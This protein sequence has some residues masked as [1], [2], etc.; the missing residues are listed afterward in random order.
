MSKE[1]TPIIVANTHWDLPE[2]IIKYVQEERM[3]NGLIDMATPLSSEE[4]VGFAEVVAYIMPE[5][6]QRPVASDVAKI[7]LYCTT[8]LMKRHKIEVPED[9]AIN[10]L[11]DYEMQKLNDLKRRIYKQRGGKEK[12]PLINAFKEVFKK[13]NLKSKIKGEKLK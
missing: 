9:I 2:N 6:Q 3:I 8:Q 7:Y 4:S 10:E 1:N 13:S 12:N 11:T 5:T